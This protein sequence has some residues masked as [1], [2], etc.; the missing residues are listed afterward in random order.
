MGFWKQMKDLMPILLLSLLVFVVVYGI[1]LVVSN[2]WVQIIVGGSVGVVLYLGI[3][4][5]F[6]FEELDDLKYMLAR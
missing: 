5:L 6:R 3:A 1:T 2:E 4:Y